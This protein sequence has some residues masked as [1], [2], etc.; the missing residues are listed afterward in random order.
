MDVVESRGALPACEAVVAA[1]Y[2][3]SRSEVYHMVYRASVG[4]FGRF[5]ILTVNARFEGLRDR[6]QHGC[7]RH[8]MRSSAHHGL[9]SE[10]ALHGFGRVGPPITDEQKLIPTTEELIPTA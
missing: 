8:K 10:A 3:Y 2:G 4:N 7:R 9:A 5:P 6:A 1:G